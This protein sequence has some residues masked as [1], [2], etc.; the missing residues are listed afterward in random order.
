MLI[1][2]NG[3]LLIE[4]QNLLQNGYIHVFIWSVLLDIGSGLIKGFVIKDSN[5]TRGLLGIVKHLLIVVLV[6]VAVPYLNIAGFQEVANWFV[7]FY[8]AAYGI[9]IVENWGQLGLPLPQFVK[10]TLTKLKD[11]SDKASK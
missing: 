8:I 6:L 2:N 11:D 1:I 5:S 10:D 7:L 9:S 4:F 3:Q